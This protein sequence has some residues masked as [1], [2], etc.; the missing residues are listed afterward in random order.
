MEQNKKYY[1]NLI[2]SITVTVSLSVA[3]ILLVIPIVLA[4]TGNVLEGTNIKVLIIAISLIFGPICALLIYCIIR[5]CYGFYI[6][7][8]DRIIYRSL[9]SKKM[10]AY[11]DILKIEVKEEFALVLGIYKSEKLIVYDAKTI[12]KIFMNNKNKDTILNYAKNLAKYC[13]N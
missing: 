5:Y 9:Y 6:I 8:E 1:N 13:C 10:I 12:I 3:I 4:V 11:Q 2:D 7:Q